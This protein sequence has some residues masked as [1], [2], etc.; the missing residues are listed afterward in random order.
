MKKIVVSTLASV[1]FAVGAF[2]QGSVTVD[3]TTA[4]GYVDINGSSGA[5][6]AYSG[7]GSL[8]LWYL[9]GTTVPGGING[10]NGVGGNTTAYAALTTDGF[11]LANTYRSVSYASG[12]FSLAE[13]DIAG[14]NPAGANTTFAVVCWTTQ[15]AFGVGTGN[16]NVYAFANP[17]ANYTAL[18]KPAAPYL[19]GFTANMDMT[20]FAT[21]E[22]TSIA[23]AGMGLAAF[24]VG[25]RRK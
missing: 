7:T 20:P 9:N 4:A 10:Q 8:Q 14:V 19:T 23:F 17:T 22:P 2:A 11:T 21:P 16:G 13:F 3:N 25:R 12:G 15:G 5:A 6:T 1:A 24:L 18:P